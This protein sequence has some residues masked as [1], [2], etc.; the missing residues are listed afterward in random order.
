M[1]LVLRKPPADSRVCDVERMRALILQSAL[2]NRGL[3]KPS[4]SQSLDDA[5]LMRYS[6]CRLQ[7]GS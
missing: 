5:K 3:A 2:I 1:S 7:Q 4:I 6:Y